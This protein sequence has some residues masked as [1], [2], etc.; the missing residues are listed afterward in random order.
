LDVICDL[1]G[2]EA[3]QLDKRVVVSSIRSVE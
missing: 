3:S 1:E 2:R